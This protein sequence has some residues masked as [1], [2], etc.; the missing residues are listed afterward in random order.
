MVAAYQVEWMPWPVK[1]APEPES[2]GQALKRL[3]DGRPLKEISAATG[4]AISTLNSYESDAPGRP[5]DGTLKK[6][7]DF[8]GV[9]DELFDIDDAHRRW[10]RTFEPLPGP[11]IALPAEPGMEELA[12]ELILLG[13]Q[14]P[15]LA[16]VVRTFRIQFK[17]QQARHEEGEHERHAG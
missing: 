17:E 14:I 1:V 7:S 4:V 15:E 10:E 6:L 11:G 13:G 9:R 12:N 5:N 16:K 3:R 8:Y 2:L